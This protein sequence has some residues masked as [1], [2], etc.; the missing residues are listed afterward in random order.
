M[1]RDWKNKV[2]V[3]NRSGRVRG[4]PVGRREQKEQGKGG[5]KGRL[6]QGGVSRLPKKWGVS[7]MQRLKGES[8]GWELGGGEGGPVSR[9]MPAGACKYVVK[10]SW[11]RNDC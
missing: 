3:Q 1:E 2:D 4:V 11:E 10:V 8:F 6:F 9:A 7:K 5:Y